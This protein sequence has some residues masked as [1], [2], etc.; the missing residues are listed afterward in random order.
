MTGLVVPI[1]VTAKYRS[2]D[3]DVAVSIVTGLVGSKLS[4]NE[5]TKRE[6]PAN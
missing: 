3:V 2:R 4:D 1:C 6:F 5:P